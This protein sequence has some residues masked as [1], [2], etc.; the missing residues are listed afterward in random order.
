MPKLWQTKS[1]LCWYVWLWGGKTI[2]KRITSII[3]ILVISLCFFTSCKGKEL[4]KADLNYINVVDNNSSEWDVEIN[5]HDS[6][7]FV[8]KIAF[9]EYH[10][11]LLFFVSYPKTNISGN[12]STYY[13]TGYYVTETEMT[14]IENPYSKEFSPFIARTDGDEGTYWSN[15]TDTVDIIKTAYEK[16]KF[17]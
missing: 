10:D 9:F 13:G 12:L 3:A 15:D 14:E 17:K 1:K 2:M 5:H 6:T 7:F 8:E 4:T 16:Y 11:S